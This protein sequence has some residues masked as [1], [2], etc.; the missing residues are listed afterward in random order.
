MTQYSTLGRTVGQFPNGQ[1]SRQSFSRRMIRA[2]SRGVSSELRFEVS[3]HPPKTTHASNTLNRRCIVR[4][5]YFALLPVGW[6][7]RADVPRRIALSSWSSLPNPTPILAL[8]SP[9]GLAGR[10]AEGRLARTRRSPPGR[11]PVGR[12]GPRLPGQSSPRF[13]AQ[14]PPRYR[15]RSPTALLRAQTPEG[16]ELS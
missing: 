12:S 11:L 6:I 10:P 13:G 4:N 5:T 8:L 14:R 15:S 1:A 16:L 2:F 9:L 3:S 7:P